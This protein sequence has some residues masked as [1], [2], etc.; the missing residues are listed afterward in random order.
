MASARQLCSFVCDVAVFHRQKM[1]VMDQS[2]WQVLLAMRCV[3]G[4]VLNST[5]NGA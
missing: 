3:S 2:H 5:I 1:L 4:G